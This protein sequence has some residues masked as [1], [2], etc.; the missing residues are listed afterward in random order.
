MNKTFKIVMILLLI[1]LGSV[2][3]FWPKHRITGGFPG[4]LVG[5]NQRFYM[6][7]YSCFGISRDFCLPWPDYG[8]DYFCHG[9][10]F[11]KKCYEQYY[12]NAPEGGPSI[13]EQVSCK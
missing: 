6:E 2:V 3:F 10:L 4:K 9:I 13:K 12:T 8:C 11:N 7:E 1:V 5:E